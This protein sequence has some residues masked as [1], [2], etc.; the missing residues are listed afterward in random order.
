MPGFFGLLPKLC[1]KGN[2]CSSFNDGDL[3]FLKLLFLFKV[4]KQMLSSQMCFFAAVKE[5][6]FIMWHHLTIN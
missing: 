3:H 4:F 2:K 5:G 6:L 1:V